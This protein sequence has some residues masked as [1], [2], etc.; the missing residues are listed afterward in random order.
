MCRMYFS[1]VLLVLAASSAVSQLT[2]S[3]SALP[4]VEG[5]PEVNEVASSVAAAL[6]GGRQVGQL[7]PISNC[8]R[9]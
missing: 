8:S 6:T 4:H 3:S 2:L 7:L 9:L 1:K 5:L